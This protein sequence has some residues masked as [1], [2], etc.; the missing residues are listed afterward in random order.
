MLENEVWEKKN[1]FAYEFDRE[2]EWSTAPWC[3]SYIY[4]MVSELPLLMNQYS[5]D[6]QMNKKGYGVKLAVVTGDGAL[7]PKHIDNI[8]LPDMRKISLIY[9]LNPNWKEE[10]GGQFRFHTS[11]NIVSIKPKLD[12]LVIF[13]SDL[14]VHDVLPYN[15]PSLTSDYHRYALTIWLLTDNKDQILNKN[16][17]HYDNVKLHFD[18]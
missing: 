7:Y 12:T 2:N 15:P 4:K 18:L 11:N 3:F 14:M 9:Y 6:L 8:G 1:V 5:A 10:Y 17:K 13:W 16:S